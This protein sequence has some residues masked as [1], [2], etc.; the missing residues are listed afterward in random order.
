MVVENH[1]SLEMFL[2]KS[3][4][5]KGG[6]YKLTSARFEIIDIFDIKGFPSTLVFDSDGIFLKEFAGEMKVEKLNL[7]IR[8]CLNQEL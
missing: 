7:K 5:N 3:N 6:R 1:D 2:E 4:L 8:E